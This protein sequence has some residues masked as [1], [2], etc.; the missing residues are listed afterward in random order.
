M[1]KKTFFRVKPTAEDIFKHRSFL[2]RF[3]VR[4]RMEAQKIERLVRLTPFLTLHTLETGEKVVF[5]KGV[6]AC[7][8]LE[9]LVSHIKAVTQSDSYW[10]QDLELIQFRGDVVFF[11]G[12]EGCTT[13][14]RQAVRGAKNNVNST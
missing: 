13:F 6:C 9:E 4:D 11:Y 2:M 14:S 1:S 12:D 3:L 5:G 7:D 10:M 8:S